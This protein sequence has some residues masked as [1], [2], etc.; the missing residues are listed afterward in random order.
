MCGT[1]GLR[2]ADVCFAHF[3]ESASWARGGD[4][5]DRPSRQH[6]HDQERDQRLGHHQQL[7]PPG[8]D[9]GVGGAERGRGIEGEEEIIDETGRPALDQAIVVLL[10]L[11][12]GEVGA[13][14]PTRVG[15]VGLCGDG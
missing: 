12:E 4:G 3:T 9:Q 6:R 11:R 14:V 2:L 15:S 7:H 5:I 10:L 8:E 1:V 13:A